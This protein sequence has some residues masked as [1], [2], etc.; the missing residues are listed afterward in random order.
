MTHKQIRQNLINE[1]LVTAS[2][3]ESALRNLAQ[4]EHTHIQ[5]YDLQ[6]LYLSLTLITDQLDEMYP[7]D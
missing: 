5:Q 4:A 3:F 2:A 1:A 6:R 7:N